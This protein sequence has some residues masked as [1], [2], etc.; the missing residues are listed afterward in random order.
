MIDMD[1]EK[2]RAALVAML[3]GYTPMEADATRDSLIAEY[4][5]LD[6]GTLSHSGGRSV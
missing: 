1:K 4:E 3:H 5:A 2:R 6:G